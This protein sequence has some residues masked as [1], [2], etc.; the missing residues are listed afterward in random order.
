MSTQALPDRVVAK[1]IKWPPSNDKKAWHSFDEDVCNII[2]ATCSGNI[3]QRFNTM[4]KLIVSYASEQFGHFEKTEKVYTQNRHEEKIKT[5]R[6]ELRSLK[7]QFRKANKEEHPALTELRDIL[8]GKL[9]TLQR[10]EGHCWRRKEQAKKRTSFISDPFGFNRRLLGDKRSG[11]LECSKD[12]VD[13][14]L[15]NS[16]KDPKRDVELGHNDRL[17][18]PKPPEVGFSTTIPSLIEIKSIV[19]AA[20]SASSPGPSSV[21]YSVY[22]CCPGLLLKLW[23][24]IKVIW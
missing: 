17:I 14:F 8:R 16:F 24:F 1:P 7:K 21:P 10:A 2:Q 18:K 3:D 4:N 19:L 12:R 6:L 22:K 11:R 23:K 15:K 9:K 5:L 13:S 20:R